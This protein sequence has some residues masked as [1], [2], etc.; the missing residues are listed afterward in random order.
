MLV[1]VWILTRD[2]LPD[3]SIKMAAVGS[4]AI[5]KKQIAATFKKTKFVL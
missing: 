1:P 4:F 2:V 5:R 3:K